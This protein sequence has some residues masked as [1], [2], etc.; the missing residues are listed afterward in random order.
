MRD[1][2]Y[3]NTINAKDLID[4]RNLAGD[5]HMVIFGESGSGKSYAIK[6]DIANILNTRLRDKV[7]VVDAYADYSEL[8][9][10]YKGVNC[11]INTTGTSVM[12]NAEDIS[13][14]ANL[15]VLNI[16]NVPYRLWIPAYLVCLKWAYSKIQE[17]NANGITTWLYLEEATI[18]SDDGD[19]EFFI[20]KMMETLWGFKCRITYATKSYEA[21]MD[22][23]TGR[24]IVSNSATA[25]IL[26]T[27]KRHAEMLQTHYGF[28][29]KCVRILTE[30]PLGKG[31]LVQRRKNIPF[32]IDK[33]PSVL[34]L[35]IKKKWFDMIA[36][37]EKQEEYRDIKPYY[38]ARFSKLFKNPGDKAIII[39]RNGYS[40]Q[41][42]IIE[43]ECTLK[44]GHG[45]PE[46]GAEPDTDYYIL[47]I[48][49]AIMQNSNL[50]A[51][52]VRYQRM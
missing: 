37:G 23:A 42:P 48:S 46:W 31:M 26:R 30:L 39:F 16:G 50:I 12:L 52:Y 35:P 3:R 27:T 25:L 21:M 33:E 14:N 7:I 20:R 28:S 36:S 47:S 5:H 41:S 4:M 49:H 2:T 6:K 8:A 43:A 19:L 44:K 34:I 11:R 51:K 32:S 17:N 22:T 40:I 29:D 18:S 1:N 15:T 9:E 13:T 24:C 10:T 45:K 38:T